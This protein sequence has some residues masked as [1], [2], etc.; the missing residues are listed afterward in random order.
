[1]KN[2]G[3]PDIQSQVSLEFTDLGSIRADFY[4]YRRKIIIKILVLERK[5]CYHFPG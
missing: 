4:C 2:M 5:T 3:N 1:M